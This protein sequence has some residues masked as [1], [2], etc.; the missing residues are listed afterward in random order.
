MTLRAGLAAAGGIVL[1]VQAAAQD[2]PDTDLRDLRIGMA[3]TELP[4]AGYADFSCAAAAAVRI[5]GWPDWHDCPAGD[6][7]LRALRFGYDATSRD[8]TVVAGHPV[9]LTAVID[10]SGTLE[11]L[12]IET[13]P[14]ARPY[15]RKRAF[16]LGPQVQARY[17]GEAWSCTQGSPQAGEESIGGVYLRERCTKTLTG[18]SL[19]I[20]RNLFRHSGGDAPSIVDETRVTIFRAHAGTGMGSH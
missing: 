20:E 10:N 12:K 3:V 19:A 1:A 2:L 17:G 6:D 18:R 15:L 14:A 7:G 8:G 16:L 4:S 13:D 9:I 11:G 5:V